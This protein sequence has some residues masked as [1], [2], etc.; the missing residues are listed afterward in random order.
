MAVRLIKQGSPEQARIEPLAMTAHPD[1]DLPG[2]FDNP[3]DFFSQGSAA[4][5]A[6]GR[7]AMPPASTEIPPQIDLAQIERSAFEN[8][9][10]QGEKAGME[11]AEKRV[12][13]LMRRFGDA[14]LELGRAKSAIYKEVEREV[15]RLSVEIAKKIVHREIQ[16]DQEII[17]TL[18]RVALGHVAERSPATIR[19]HP[20]D[21]AYLTERHPGWVEDSGS[22]RQ[23]AMVADKTVERGG[24]LIQTE[25]G[26]VDARIEEEFHEVER[27]FFEGPG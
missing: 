16:V 21:Y 8:G 26:D 11:I 6:S 23:I 25:C 9:F 1:S 13:V 10:H 5:P 20:L 24:C 12:E 14:I 2:V 15:V 27:V 17:Q 18:V 19:I 3:A 22:G 4:H 7:D